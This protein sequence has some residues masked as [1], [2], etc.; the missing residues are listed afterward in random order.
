MLQTLSLYQNH[1]SEFS[2]QYL[3][4][5]TQL[6][7]TGRAGNAVQVAKSLQDSTNQPLSAQAVQN[8]MKDEGCGEEEKA[9]P[10]II[11]Q[12]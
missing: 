5:A 1:P 7:G 6:I 8:Y 4:Y 10:S 3:C 11:S 2:E 12:L 9:T